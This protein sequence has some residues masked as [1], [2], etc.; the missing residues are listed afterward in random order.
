MKKHLDSSWLVCGCK[1]ANPREGLGASVTETIFPGTKIPPKKGTRMDNLLRC[2]MKWLCEHCNKIESM[3]QQTNL[4]DAV[5]WARKNHMTVTMTT[6][7]IP[8]HVGHTLLTSLQMLRLMKEKI[9]SS[10]TYTKLRKD[11]GC[12]SV[13]KL[14]VTFG[15]R[16]GWHPHYHI[17]HF[18]SRELADD[19]V[20]KLETELSERLRDFLLGAK[21]EK[22]NQG[23]Q[24]NLETPWMSVETAKHFSQYG[25]DVKKVAD[26]DL[27]RAVVQYFG[28]DGDDGQDCCGDDGADGGEKIVR[29]MN[30]KTSGSVKPTNLQPLYDIKPRAMDEFRVMMAAEKAAEKAA[31]AA[32]RARE[33]RVAADG[34]APEDRAAAVRKAKRAEA[35]AGATAEAAREAAE[36]AK[37]RTYLKVWLEYAASMF[38]QTMFFWSKGLKKTVEG[39]SVPDP[40]KPVTVATRVLTFTPAD[41]DGKILPGLHHFMI[42]YLLHR[43]S[44]EGNQEA[45]RQ[46]WTYFDAEDICP[47]LAPDRPPDMVPPSI[48]E[49]SE[50]VRDANARTGFWRAFEAISLADQPPVSG[51]GGPEPLDVLWPMARLLLGIVGTA[52]ETASEMWLMEMVEGFDESVLD[53]VIRR[54]GYAFPSPYRFDKERIVR[55]ALANLVGGLDGGRASGFVSGVYYALF[56]EL[57]P[58]GPPPV[59]GGRL[60]ELCGIPEC[61]GITPIEDLGIP[62]FDT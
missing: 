54:L 17:L 29:E 24:K 38:G 21:G 47:L 1:R 20:K 7:T 19:E 30:A 61:P 43:S 45:L 6:I 28:K 41:S 3:V 51:P 59:P 18:W 42:E 36:K 56:G 55:D 53:G 22:K 44:N 8:H 23:K 62:L 34:A 9:Y 5:A 40:N 11:C 25:V 10:G 14:E 37:G 16:Y 32:S 60:L 50:A 33:A 58:G 31:E 4:E 27:D 48:R 15:F 46:M 52:R 35:R 12:G 39:S 57:P 13:V 49:T 2:D 26:G